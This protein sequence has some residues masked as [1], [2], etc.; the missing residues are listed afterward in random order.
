MLN[1]SKFEIKIEKI[2][3]KSKELVL[4]STSHGLPNIFRSQHSAIKLMWICLFTASI[5]MGFYMV[6]RSII[7][8]LDFE[9]VTKINV[10]NE[11]PTQ[12]PAI[13]IYNLKDQ[14]SNISLS[15]IIFACLYSGGACSPDNDFDLIQDKFGYVSY[16]FKKRASYL[17]GQS[18]GLTL[19]I[20]NNIDILNS[21]DSKNATL[22][23]A[24]AS[25]AQPVLIGSTIKCLKTAGTLSMTSDANS[26]TLTH[27]SNIPI[28]TTG[29]LIASSGTREG[30]AAWT[31]IIA[32][33][34]AGQ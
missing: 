10:I 4:V 30:G 13:T 22:T 24:S 5:S 32:T 28:L 8:Y 15:S 7:E 34:T 14:K 20:V 1:Q 16:R 23:A 19:I 3:S 26:I 6:T 33:N 29:E 12:F 31:G 27:G 18:S 2:K 17:G 9:T 25:G 11:T 21:L